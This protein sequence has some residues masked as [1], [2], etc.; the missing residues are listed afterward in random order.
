MADPIAGG[1]SPWLASV[2][3]NRARPF[4]HGAVLDYGCGVGALSD[5][6]DPSRYL[7]VDIDRKSL[8]DARA[9]HAQCRFVDEAPSASQKFDTIVA[10]AAIERSADRASLLALF[11]RLLAPHGRIVLTTPHPSLEWAHTLGA[12]IGLFNSEVSAQHEELIDLRHMRAL[13]ASAGLVVRQY[14]RF[15]FGANQLFVLGHAGS[16]LE[17]EAEP[18][19]NE[20]DAR[21][22]AGQ[23][24]H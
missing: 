4:L 19:P 6:C 22:T 21:R 20:R 9:R 23:R 16:G 1:L 2:R 5:F 8:A 11:S 14:E 18:R 10:L 15:L 13:A 7:G 24:S 12:R 3:L 17:I